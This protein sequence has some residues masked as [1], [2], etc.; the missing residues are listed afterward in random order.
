MEGGKEYT[1]CKEDVNMEK[2]KIRNSRILF[3]LKCLLLAYV[4][5]GGLLMLL[6]L[7]L[8]KFRLSEQV[9]SAAVI[10]IYLA[11]VFPTGFLAGKR[12]EKRKFLWGLMA[13]MAYF[14]VMVLVSLAVNRQ[15]QGSG[16]RILT[17]MVIC[18]AGGMLGGMLS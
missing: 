9:V 16:T 6:A 11:A 2:K 7:L 4:L 1:C 17:T 5:T 10:L 15:L 14:A 13:G 18:G 3:L 8:Y 12:M